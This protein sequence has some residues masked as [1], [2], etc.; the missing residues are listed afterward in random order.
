MCLKFTIKFHRTNIRLYSVLFL[1]NAILDSNNT[2]NTTTISKISPPAR[3]DQEKSYDLI[4][5]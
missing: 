3:A 2:K 5:N 4:L 1:P